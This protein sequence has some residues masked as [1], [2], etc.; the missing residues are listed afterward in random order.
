MAAFEYGVGD[1]IVT[2][3]NE[4]LARIQQGVKYEIVVPKNT[5]RIEN[6]AAVVDTFV[7]KHGTRKVAEAFIDYLWSEEA[8]RIFADHGFRPVNEKVLS[9]KKEQ[10]IDP[11]G[12][13]DIQYLGGWS[14]VKDTLYS[15]KGVWYQ[16]LAGL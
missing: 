5:I 9:E 3:E 7:D 16:V 8:Q 4:L 15:K 6:P 14:K 1:V 12:L 10:Y 2:Y 13:F 11:P